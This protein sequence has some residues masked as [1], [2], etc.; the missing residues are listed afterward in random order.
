MDYPQIKQIN[1]VVWHID[2][3]PIVVEPGGGGIQSLEPF[4]ERMYRLYK[5]EV[6][7]REHYQSASLH[8]MHQIVSLKGWITRLKRTLKKETEFAQSKFHSYSLAHNAALKTLCDNLNKRDAEVKHLTQRLDG[9]DRTNKAVIAQNKLLMERLAEW[10][11]F[12]SPPKGEIPTAPIPTG[13]SQCS[14]NC[15]ERGKCD[16]S[17]AGQLPEDTLLLLHRKQDQ[18]ESGRV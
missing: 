6:R 17:C 16:G 14:W 7:D 11:A 12:C 1:S 4:A 10:E 15:V 9:A 13:R 3:K 5:S 18:D 2:G 8:R